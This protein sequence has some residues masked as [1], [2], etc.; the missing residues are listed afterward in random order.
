MPSSREGLEGDLRQSDHLAFRKL[1]DSLGDGTPTTR[2]D[3][4]GGP[5]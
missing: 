5:F 4:A 3:R 1:A 2:Q